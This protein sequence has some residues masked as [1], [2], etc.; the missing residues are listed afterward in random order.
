[1]MLKM[2]IINKNTGVVIASQ[3]GSNDEL[4]KWYAQNKASFGDIYSYQT[5]IS[6]YVEPK[7]KSKWW[8]F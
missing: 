1:M 2:E 4:S 6:D 7:P 3:T 8:P 5:K